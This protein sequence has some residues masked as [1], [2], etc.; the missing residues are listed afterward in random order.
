[1]DWYDFVFV[2]LFGISIGYFM[3]RVLMMCD[4][5]NEIHKKYIREGE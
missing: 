2:I 4:R 3:I 1:M 5:V